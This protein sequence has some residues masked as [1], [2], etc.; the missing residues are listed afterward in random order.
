MNKYI[1]IGKILNFHGI[2]GEA[3]VGYSKN[4][5]EFI[6]K[7]ESV[8]IFKNEQYLEFKIKSVKLN[9][10]FAIIKFEAINTIEEILEYKNCLI[11]VE[12]TDLKQDLKE[13]EFLIQDLIGMEVFSDDIKLGIITGV[14]S[15]GATDLLCIKT[16]SE[17]IS[18]VPFVK[19]LVPEININEKKLIIKN[20][21]GLIE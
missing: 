3:K 11:Y 21:E 14:S 8:F 6:S 10:K 18:L 13:D 1:S 2:Q 12:E 15:N 9:S 4:Q 19:E 7:L 20:I 16:R 5:S 17:K